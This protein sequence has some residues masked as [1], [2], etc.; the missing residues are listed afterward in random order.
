MT[1][2]NTASQQNVNI[3]PTQVQPGS[4]TFN[5]TAKNFS[6]TGGYISGST[7]LVLNSNYTG[8]VSLA[9]TGTNDFT[10]AIAINAGTLEIGSGGIAGTNNISGAGV[11]E[12]TGTGTL[13]LSSNNYGFA[14]ATAVDGGK[15]I[16]GN[17]NALG[18]TDTSTA[19]TL[20]NSGTLDIAGYTLGTRQVTFQG[21]VRAGA[22]VSNSGA[23][24]QNAL[25]YVTML[26]NATFGGSARWDIRGDFATLTGN[27]YSLTKV[28]T[29]LV[30]LNGL[31]ST[32][33][34]TVAINE[35]I[36]SIEG[37][38]TLGDAT[39][40]ATVNSGAKLV[41]VSD[42]HDQCD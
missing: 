32:N 19:I 37:T 38:T 4:I 18:P 7:G 1:F 20:S 30:A 2:D 16:M 14:G 13:T 8:K 3:A 33:L 10:G 22:I 34:G 25:R 36:L 40:T 27:G 11:L 35:G 29:N 21:T 6:F 31:G 15:L 42:R 12:K 9:N 41:A 23:D 17:A 24:Q 28:G 39:K 5:N 26:G